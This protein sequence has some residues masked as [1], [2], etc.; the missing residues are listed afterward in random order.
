MPYYIWLK[1]CYFFEGKLTNTQ[2]GDFSLSTE[3][4][5]TNAWFIFDIISKSLAIQV[6]EAGHLA[7]TSENCPFF[8]YSA[9]TDRLSWLANEKYDSF[10]QLLAKRFAPAFSKS[11]RKSL[12]K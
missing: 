8:H 6:S 9:D 12:L 3:V 11:L 7:S 5:Y 4:I 2:K 10:A 1:F